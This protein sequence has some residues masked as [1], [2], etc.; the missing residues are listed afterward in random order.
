[1]TDVSGAA[2]TEA[3]GRRS[4]SDRPASGRFPEQQSAEISVGLIGSGRRRIEAIE[5]RLAAELA[6]ERLC[7]ADAEEV[8]P[9]SEAK[10]ELG[11]A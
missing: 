6:A 8:V 9:W 11:L 1:M 5:D 2:K 7:G 3:Q 10:K 4:G